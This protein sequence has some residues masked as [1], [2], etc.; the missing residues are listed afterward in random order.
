M[1]EEAISIINVRDHLIVTI[2]QDPS[3]A[4]LNLMQEKVLAAMERCHSTGVIFDL[5]A[6]NSL[7]SYF[8]RMMAETASMVKVMGGT[9]IAAGIQPSVAIT[10]VQL[11]LTLKGVITALN[12]NRAMD[13]LEKAGS[14]T[15]GSRL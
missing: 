7:D 1:N 12:L 15:G 10:L 11:G 2:P 14:R 8:A 9:T 4:G 3:D 6:V 13:V 5:S